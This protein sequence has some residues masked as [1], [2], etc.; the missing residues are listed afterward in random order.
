M[1]PSFIQTTALLLSSSPLPLLAFTPQCRPLHSQTSLFA[2]RTNAP[3]SPSTVIDPDG[4]T[5]SQE[6][7][8][9]PEVDLDTQPEGQYDE[10][11]HPVPHQPWR[12]GDTDGC[13]DPISAPWRLEAESIVSDAVN[14]V[15][16]KVVDVTWYMAKCVISLDEPSFKNV[17]SYVDGPEVRIMYPDASDVSGHMFNDPEVGTEDEMF[18]EEDELL[19][20]EQYD[21]D[22]E[23]EILKANMPQEYDEVTGEEL[24]PREPRSRE[25]RMMEMQ[26]EWESRWLDEARN[27]KPSD[28]M[29]SHPVDTKAL[30]VLSQAIT[31][32]LSEEIIEEKLQI[33][34]RHDIIL[35]SPLDNPCILDSQKE[36]DAAR[37][38]DVYVET[39][40]PWGS[41]RVLGGK[42]VDRNAMDVI[43]NQDNTG[44][45]VTIPNSMIHQVLLPSGL[46]KGSAKMKSDMEEGDDGDEGGVGD[47]EE[48]EIFE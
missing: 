12:R 11:N 18:T 34:S 7:D 1:T 43:I 21:D 48:E 15:G 2:S 37:D 40:D 23:Y 17:V 28:G 19:D 14:L 27:E 20:Y 6:P 29:F 42:L 9:F 26:E 3:F 16:G 39:R 13:H 35:T 41:N 32:A 25:S 44:R 5:P 36:F 38:L 10:D 47:V 4:P 33:L 30:S 22:T 24:P 46:A 45:M 8:P 31:K